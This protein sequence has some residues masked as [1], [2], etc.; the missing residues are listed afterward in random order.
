MDDSR[1]DALVEIAGTPPL[2]LIGSRGE[3]LY[4]QCVAEGL[5]EFRGDLAADGNSFIQGL[6]DIVF[7]H[8]LFSKI[9]HCR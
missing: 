1:D 5:A 8:G 7:H 2:E 6:F 4:R 3:A 9:C